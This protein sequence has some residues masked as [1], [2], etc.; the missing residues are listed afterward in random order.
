MDY[1]RSWTQNK[2]PQYLSE[3]LTHKLFFQCKKSEKSLYSNKIEISV[4]ITCP[5]A[6]NL[7]GIHWIQTKKTQ[8]FVSLSSL[9]KRKNLQEVTCKKRHSTYLVITTLIM[10]Q[11]IDFRFI[12]KHPHKQLKNISHTISDIP[13]LTWLILF[14]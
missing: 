13:T 3:S 6:H 8:F 4:E 1:E 9:P 10:N 2:N 12:E 5:H 11:S 14:S 7:N